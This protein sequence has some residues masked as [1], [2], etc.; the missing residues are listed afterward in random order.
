MLEDDYDSEFRL[1]GSPLEPIQSLDRQGRVIY[2]GTFSKVLL[3]TLRVGYVVAPASLM[4]SLRAARKLS[5]S[6]GPPET[7]RALADLLESGLFS[8]HLRRLLRV[9]R[10]RRDALVVVIDRHLGSVLERLPSAAGLHLAARCRDDRLD[11]AVWVARA[12]AV[13][14]AIESLVPYAVHHPIPGLAFG[15]GLVDE[16]RI[17]E[18]VRRL[19][20]SVPARR[21]C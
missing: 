3:P 4:P 20:A 11:V 17:G 15:Y 2:V 7:Q 9:Y 12:R 6:H 8:R 19:A 18:G 16:R 13:G 1:D 10:A 14:V 21:V 5:D